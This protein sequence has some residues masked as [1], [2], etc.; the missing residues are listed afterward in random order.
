MSK[1]REKLQ[2]KV[3]GPGHC[4]QC[5]GFD[6]ALLGGQ[7]PRCL[8]SIGL[9]LTEPGQS[10][11][12]GAECDDGAFPLLASIARYRIIRQIGEGGMGVV[13]EAEQE[14]PS[15]TV[16]LK[17]LKPGFATPE[18]LRR[19]ED[20][21]Q[22]L[23]R[24][25]HPG[26]AQIYEAGTAD[27]GSGPQPYFAM[28]LIRGTFLT[29]Y[30]STRHLGTRERLAL[31]A[32]VAEAVHHAHQRGLIHRDLKPGN[33]LVDEG[34]Q[35]KIVD[36]G[37]AR[38]IDLEVQRT[39]QTDIGRLIGTLAYMSP[40]QAGAD[41]FEIDIRTDVYALGVLLYELLSGRPMFV[42]KRLDEAIQAI[43]EEDPARLSSVNRA[44][45]GD[46]ETITAK[47][48]EKDKTR[49]YTSAAELAADIGRYLR[50]EPI[51]ARPA[52]A[53]YQLRKFARRNQG[54]MAGAVAGLSAL[55][56]GLGAAT[57]QTARARQA[58]QEALQE[59]D[60]AQRAEAS[61]SLQ[62]GRAAK[63]EAAATAERNL[64][65]EAGKLAAA[66]SDRSLA[67]ENA[68]R[69]DRD[70]TTWQHLTRESVRLSGTRADDDLAALLARQAFLI[71]QRGPASQS[72]LVENALQQVRR[73]T[74]WS[75]SLPLGYQTDIRFIAFTPDGLRLA[76]NGPDGSI[77]LLDLRQRPSPVQFLKG[78]PGLGP[79]LFAAFSRDGKWLATG[80]YE[81][82]GARGNALLPAPVKLWD[83][84]Q[85][86]SP[87]RL[88]HGHPREVS[89]GMFSLDGKRLAT[90]DSQR[91][92]LWD[93]E[94]LSNDPELL[95]PVRTGVFYFFGCV[96]S[97]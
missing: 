68:M 26:I 95:Q 32:K 34:G 29:E 69:Q 91:V 13:Y 86:N 24:L 96:F 33:I 20:E 44:Y 37:V 27:T 57:W 10:S 65:V 43:R 41:P 7:C 66:A 58:G 11:G 9:E 23:G 74:W 12:A 84:T 87:P 64:A 55:L 83:L 77:A 19:F 80:G 45:R 62:A 93:M 31:V 18:L 2:E 46:I 89:G 73:A 5:G 92:L 4:A 25:Q 59:S 49:R 22:A 1:T 42:K 97:E 72:A 67:A 56:I 15:R 28:E 8:M 38:V 40:E 35:P 63:A 21:A 14:H 61:M 54:L 50:D 52:S 39:V 48:L 16:A 79:V 75:H 53:G 85:P 6:E 94:N 3:D 78:Q 82:S 51:V 17:V 47:A 88:L 60:R 71:E 81:G 70:R 36:F 76:T 30:A 90:T